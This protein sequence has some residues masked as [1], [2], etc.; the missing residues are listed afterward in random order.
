LI[1]GLGQNQ[2]IIGVGSVFVVNSTAPSVLRA[3]PAAGTAVFPTFLC[4]SRPQFFSPFLPGSARGIDGGAASR[5]P[6][7]T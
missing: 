4:H 3:L 6:E 1:A 7:E 5:V 2:K